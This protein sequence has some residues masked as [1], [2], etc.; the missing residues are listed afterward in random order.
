MYNSIVRKRI[1]II[2]VRFC[3]VANG[4]NVHAIAR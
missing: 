1:E 3:Y 2:S 4:V